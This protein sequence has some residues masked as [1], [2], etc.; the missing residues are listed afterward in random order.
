MYIHDWIWT[1]TTFKELLAAFMHLLGSIFIEFSQKI[2]YTYTARKA[3]LVRER[4]I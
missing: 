4:I 3:E 2:L 1:I